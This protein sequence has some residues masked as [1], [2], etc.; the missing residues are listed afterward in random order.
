MVE[1]NQE[2]LEAEETIA[3]LAE[4]GRRL[5]LEELWGGMLAF[6]EG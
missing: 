3:G 4:Q 5:C 6:S 2:T 1:G